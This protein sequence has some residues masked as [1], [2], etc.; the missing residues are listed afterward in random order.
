[1][2]FPAISDK[3]PCRDKSL[4]NLKGEKWKD[5][6][7]S[8]D[9]F[10]LSNYG[11]LKALSRYIENKSRKGFWK[12]DKIVTLSI[13]PHFNPLVK[14]YYYDVRGIFNYNR[15]RISFGVG[16]MVY[17]LFIKPIDF[18]KDAMMICHKDDNDLNNHVSNL[19]LLS[20]SD[21]Q[22]LSFSRKR[23]T[24]YLKVLD[25]SIRTRMLQLRAKK[26]SQYDLKGKK[27]KDYKSLS[28]AAIQ[29]GCSIGNIS[30]VASGRL[31]HTKGFVW[32]YAIKKHKQNQENM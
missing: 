16:R 30:S 28:I 12:K 17:H 6:P 4:K 18:T 5:I 15:Q 8:D 29:T 10:Q 19:L 2:N 23:Q 32:K 14:K 24:S 7:A 21:K 11:R 25:P 22:R 1:M 20:C 31:P 3:L 26:I 13:V 9:Y 27:I